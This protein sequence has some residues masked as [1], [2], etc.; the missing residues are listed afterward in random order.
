MIKLYEMKFP[1]TADDATT[2]LAC[3]RVMQKECLQSKAIHKRCIR[4]VDSSLESN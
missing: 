3:H 4:G 2:I 1:H